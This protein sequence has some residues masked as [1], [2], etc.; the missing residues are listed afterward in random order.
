MDLED[1]HPR[2]LCLWVV[3][4]IADGISTI[5]IKD[6]K[7]QADGDTVCFSLTRIMPQS[8]EVVIHANHNRLALSYNSLLVAR[9][10]PGL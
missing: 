2:Q 9:S 3:L 5:T 10:T 8:S 1:D 4:D 7:N 6:P